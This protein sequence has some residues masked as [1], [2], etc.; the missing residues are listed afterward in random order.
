MFQSL[1]IKKREIKSWKNIEER[2]SACMPTF[3]QKKI[4]LD[5]KKFIF[6]KKVQWKRCMFP[7]NHYKKNRLG[8][9]I[10]F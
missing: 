8:Y 4:D 10:F 3:H 1:Y 9:I 7:F 6:F 5:I 2:E